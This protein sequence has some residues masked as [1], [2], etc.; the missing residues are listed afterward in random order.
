MGVNY[1]SEF[2]A[3]ASAYEPVQSDLFFGLPPLILALVIALIAIAVLIGW[4]LRAEYGPKA[5][6]GCQTIWKE[7][8]EA[9]LK[10]LS[11]PTGELQARVGDLRDAIRRYLGDVLDVAKG[12]SGP[13]GELEKALKGE[14]PQEPAKPAPVPAPTCGC[15]KGGG[16]GCG[17]AH[18]G[19]GLTSAA[20]AV[21]INVSSAGGSHGGCGCGADK[22]ASKTCT[23][24]I[25]EEPKPTPMVDKKPEPKPG[26]RPMTVEEQTAAL[27]AAARKFHDHWSNKT[28]RLAEL[29]RARD[30]LN[31][32]P[33]PPKK[34]GGM[35]W[36][37]PQ[38]GHGH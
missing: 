23:C 37:R 36:D 27:A 22:D 18:G 29:R 9:S 13:F 17:G 25:A 35:V 16:C 14:V 15:G 28:D 32:P 12:V 7:I 30:L 11:A 5:G 1:A 4:F 38:D 33:S 19:G 3:A 10:A 21:S 24:K 6:D 20:V 31:N 8:H 34:P 26:V 2:P